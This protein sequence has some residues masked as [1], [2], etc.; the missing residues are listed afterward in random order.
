MSGIDDQVKWSLTK[1]GIGSRFHDASMLDEKFGKMGKA[2]YNWTR[3]NGERVV[4][5]QSF[6]FQGISFGH[7]LTMLA[8]GLHING[9]G[10]RIYPLVRMRSVL[11]DPELKEEMD[12]ALA[13]FIMPAQSGNV[14]CP[15]YPQWMEETVYYVRQ[16][17]AS[18]KAVIL[19][20]EVNDDVPWTQKAGFY[21]PDGFVGDLEHDFET[22][23]ARDLLA[24]WGGE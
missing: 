23:T 3:K 11:T 5:G 18:G 15:L 7:T 14:A 2:M 19:H 1:A 6:V 22:V 12:D 9:A 10:V 8:R 24:N 4:N 16:R 21:W 20:A 13:L 17:I